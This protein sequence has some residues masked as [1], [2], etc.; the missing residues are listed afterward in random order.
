MEQSIVYGALAIPYRIIEGRTEFLLLKHQS[1]V[2]TFPGGGKDKE[3]RTLENCL[4][5]ELVEE[6][7]LQVSLKDLQPTGLV[8]NFT[9]GP[10]KPSRNGMEGETHFWLLKLNG[11][12]KL[13]SFDKIVDHGWFTKEK[14]IELLPFP[15]ERRI[16][17]EATKEYLGI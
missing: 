8:N 9:Y 4:I 5:R 13:S 6:T 3:D 7:G 11:D 15:A 17:E 12:E 14:I 10:E 16:F 1:G 2:W